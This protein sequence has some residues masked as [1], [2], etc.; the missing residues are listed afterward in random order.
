ME[1]R[2][3]YAYSKLDE[4]LEVHKDYPM[5]MNS[6][7]IN[8]SKETRE[9]NKEQQLE[10]AMRQALIQPGQKVSIDEITRLLSTMNTKPNSDMDMVAAEEAFDNMNAYYEVGCF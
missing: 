1:E 7:F 6:Q 2:L 8:T 9:G 10:D 3:N 5:T 4:L